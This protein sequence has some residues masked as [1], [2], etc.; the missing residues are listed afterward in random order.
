MVY[1][2]WRAGSIGLAL[3]LAITGCATQGT[4]RPTA[5]LAHPAPG[6]PAAA[7]AKAPRSVPIARGDGSGNL[8]W[9]GLLAAMGRA[10]VIIVGETH[11]D[12]FGH[13]V[14]RAMVEDLLRCWP[15]S[16]VSM[17]MFERDEQHLVNTYVA[18]LLCGPAFEKETHSSDWGGKNWKTWY[19]PIVDAVRDGHGRLVAANAPLRFVTMARKDGYAALK[20]LPPLERPMV[21]LPVAKD[22][23]AYRKRFFD[24]MRQHIAASKKQSGKKPDKSGKEDAAESGKKKPAHPAMPELT[25]AQIETFFQSQRV[26]DATMGASIVRAWDKYHRKVIHFVGQFH[27]DFNGGLV[28]EVRDRKPRLR[29]LTISLQPV[30]ATQLQKDDKGRADIVIYTGEAKGP[31]RKAHDKK[32]GK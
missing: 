23:S 15:G 25:D 14:E 28:A 24:V 19:R 31:G 30:D 8:D 3:L 27:T 10:Q 9:N 20:N 16:V 12:A 17:E 21:D 4:P 6:T 13:D 32:P 5:P 18:G 22:V 11:N 26:W 29:I 7:P 2:S 1:R